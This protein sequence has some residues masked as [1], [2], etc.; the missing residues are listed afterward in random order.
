MPADIGGT[1]SV[2]GARDDAA[3]TVYSATASMIAFMKRQVQ[4]LEAIYGS[5]PAV[6]AA[7]A[8]AMANP[9]VPLDSAF[10]MIFNGATWDRYRSP[11]VFK[12]LWPPQAINTAS[13]SGALWTPAVGKKIRLMGGSISFSAAGSINFEED[14]VGMTTGTGSG[15]TRWRTPELLANTPYNFDLGQGI[16][17]SAANNV[18]TAYSDVAGNLCGTLYGTEE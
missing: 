3:A 14:A 10:M 15:V 12:F 8:E 7:L 9:T 17:F 11:N 5:S 18:L 2:F 6:A 4:L 13:V 1:Q 16:L